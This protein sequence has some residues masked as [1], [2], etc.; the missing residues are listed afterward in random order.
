LDLVADETTMPPSNRAAAETAVILI[1]VVGV[2]IERRNPRGR[3]IA[4]MRK[5]AGLAIAF[6]LCLS[7]CAP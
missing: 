1:A 2:T 5:S 3:E 7:R 6:S 4:A